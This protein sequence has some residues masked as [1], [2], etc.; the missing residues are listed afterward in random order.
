MTT[1][2]EPGSKTVREIVA[3]YLRC[4]S[5]TAAG[6]AP[7][8]NSLEFLRLSDADPMKIAAV[9]RAAAAWHRHTD[10]KTIESDLLDELAAMQAVRDE[11]LDAEY[12]RTVRILTTG[13]SRAELERRRGRAS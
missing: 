1:L 7:D 8:L 13:P 4:R 12:Q 11:Y 9:Y 3:D 10:P 6:T 5:K 2:D